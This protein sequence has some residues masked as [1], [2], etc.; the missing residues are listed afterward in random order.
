ME[1]FLFFLAAIVAGAIN[2]LAGGGGL[3]TFPL[4]TLVMPAVAA[5][6]TS[7][8]GL[9]LA[10]P[11]AVWRTRHEIAKVPR[12]LTLSLLVPSLMGGLVVALLLV[13]TNERNFTFLVPWLIL[14]G[15]VL[16]VLEPSL[17]RRSRRPRSPRM[18]PA[19]LLPVALLV[20]LVVAVYGGYFGAG[21]GIL[22]ISALSLFG[23]GDVDRV[24][25]L[26]NL[27]T[28]CLRG[29]AVVVLI[30]VGAVNWGYGVPMVIGG[31]LGGYVGG[32]ISGRANRR[33]L[34]TIVIVIGFGVAAYYFWNVY[35]GTHRIGGE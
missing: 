21:I 35:A 31:L 1:H 12:R 17:S 2:S 27:L 30:V 8:V 13:Y 11:T 34:R 6:A 22:M 16:F 15:T 32:M 9:V 28:G 26:K 18:I 5:D 4:L 10:Y 25:P 19:K 33:V 14:G 23:V 7:A 20:T 3:I 24:V 29:L